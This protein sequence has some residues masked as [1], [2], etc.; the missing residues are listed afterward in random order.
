MLNKFLITCV[1]ALAINTSVLAE[2]APKKTAEEAAKQQGREVQ[3]HLD[4]LVKYGG[5][6]AYKLVSATGGISPYGVLVLDNLD[7][8]LLEATENQN[9]KFTFKEE[10]LELKRLIKESVQKGNVVAAAF[11]VGALVPVK[12][13]TEQAGIAIELEHKL[14]LSVL[15]FVPYEY[16]IGQGDLKFLKPVDQEKPIVFFKKN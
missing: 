15:R 16:S 3:A 5:E 2:E 6:Y 10:V 14:G 8:V 7:V 9:K 13:S 11:F 12:G 4:M 1:C